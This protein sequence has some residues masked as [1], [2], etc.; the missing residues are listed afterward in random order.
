MAKKLNANEP[1]TVD[2]SNFVKGAK[3]ISTITEKWI[4]ISPNQI[5]E[6]LTSLQ[7]A[8]VEIENLVDHQIT[9]MGYQERKGKIKG[10]E[11][12]YIIAIVVPEGE[13]SPCTLITG[14]AVIVRKLRQV[15]DAEAFPVA[16]TIVERKGDFTYY[17]FIS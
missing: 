8:Q 14:A 1:V 5:Q 17:D 12:D 7:L 15:G 11:T 16:G 10:K 3:H 13:T 9:V 6:G 2:C 4:G